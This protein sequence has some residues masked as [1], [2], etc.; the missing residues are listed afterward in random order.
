[1]TEFA[2][3]NTFALFESPL[4]GDGVR[5]LVPLATGC[6][7]LHEKPLVALQTVATTKDVIVCANCMSFIGGAHLQ[8]EYLARKVSRVTLTEGD[9]LHEGFYPCAHHC[10]EIYCSIACLNEH[11]RS[12]GHQLLCTG[13][14]KDDEAE[15]HP[16]MKFKVHAC[17]TNEIFLLVAQ[18][19]AKIC[20][21][22]SS[23][24]SSGRDKTAA[25][26]AAMKPYRNYVR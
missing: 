20:S 3:P 16:L 18:V 7:V 9:R 12:G 22:V 19:F 10:G 11:W 24:L 17:T 13:L 4:G 1:M 2:S 15:T 25:V 14:V 21:S 8:M 26:D 5:A 23:S 6:K